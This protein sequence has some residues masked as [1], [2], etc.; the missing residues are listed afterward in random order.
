[1]TDSPRESFNKVALA[2]VLIQFGAEINVGSLKAGDSA[3]E[4]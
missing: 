4:S 2:V 3:P 1:M